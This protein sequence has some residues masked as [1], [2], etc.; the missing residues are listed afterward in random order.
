MLESRAQDGYKPSVFS[1]AATLSRKRAPDMSMSRSS[2]PSFDAQPAQAALVHAH[3]Q[4]TAADQHL[5]QRLRAKDERALETLY[6]RY[7]GLVF[8]LAFRIT[9]DRQ[10]AQEVL[11]DAFLRCWNSAGQF[12]DTRGHVAAWLMGIARNRAIDVLRSRQ[13]QDQ[14]REDAL[15]GG[16][17]GESNEGD[18]PVSSAH[19]DH[20]EAVLVQHTVRG[21]LASLSEPQRQVIEL[22]YYSGLTQMEI[23][24]KLST[25][26]GTIKTRMRDGLEKM[27]RDLHLLIGV[28]RRRDE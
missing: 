17:S 9:G 1:E 28:E 3:R 4:T 27:R 6:D 10:L 24:T 2:E 25:P 8:T 20:S 19:P 23:A 26:L 15:S 11:Q 18:P 12:D 5:L 16:A 22:A 13:H 14:L 7:N 21:A